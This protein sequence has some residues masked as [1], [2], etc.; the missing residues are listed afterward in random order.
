MR[1]LL[2]ATS[3]TAAAVATAGCG[4]ERAATPDTA[5]PQA[6]GGTVGVRLPADGVAFAA[7]LAWT[8]VPGTAPQ[9][10]ELASGRATVTL[11]RYPR[12]EP[13]PRTAAGLRQAQRDLEAAA[14]ARTP[15]FSATARRATRVAGHPA[16]ELRG[17]ATVDGQPRAIRSI[18]VY[19]LGAEL[20]VDAVAEPAQARR[21]DREVVAPLVRSLRL[22]APRGGG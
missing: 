14:T 16:V 21:V 12:T 8:R 7:P 6:P 10:T 11:W 5:T 22:R 13:L 17:T 9:L 3:L 4:A 1:R 18:H 15:S 2:A 20:V 19:A